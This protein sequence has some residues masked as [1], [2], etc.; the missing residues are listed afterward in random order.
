MQ[1]DV[2]IVMESAMACAIARQEYFD[3]NVLDY[4]L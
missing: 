2:G 3:L 4:D 1:L